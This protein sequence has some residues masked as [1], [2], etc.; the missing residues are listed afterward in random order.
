MHSRN[1]AIA[2]GVATAKHNPPLKAALVNPSGVLKGSTIEAGRIINMMVLDSLYSKGIRYVKY[3]SITL[4][5]LT[6][7]YICIMS[8]TRSCENASFHRYLLCFEVVGGSWGG[9]PYLYICIYNTYGSRYIHTLHSLIPH[10]PQ[11]KSFR[12]Q[13]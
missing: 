9:G 1:K 5:M 8:K 13:P 12:P 2:W 6:Y 4:V 7:I 10:N 3:T 11:G